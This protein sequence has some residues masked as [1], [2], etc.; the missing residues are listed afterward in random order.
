MTLIHSIPCSAAS[1]PSS[2]RGD[3]AAIR[4]APPSSRSPRPVSR[5]VRSVYRPGRGIYWVPMVDRSAGSVYGPGVAA[6]RPAEAV[7]RPTASELR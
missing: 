4:P 7:H 2:H 1:F 3:R 5:P 6:S